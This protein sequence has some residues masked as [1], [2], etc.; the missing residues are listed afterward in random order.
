MDPRLNLKCLQ[1][2]ALT[3]L[4]QSLYLK[5]T[6]TG[7]WRTEA[8][9]TEGES[10]PP[11]PHPLSFTLAPHVNVQNVQHF[12]ASSLY[13]SHAFI[14]PSFQRLAASLETVEIEPIFSYS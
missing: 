2:L 8:V 9:I 7:P 1:A 13:L 14:W 11:T 6:P 5:S 3:A 12:T 10:S 4:I